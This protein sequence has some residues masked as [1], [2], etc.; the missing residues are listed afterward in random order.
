MALEQV[1]YKDGM[2]ELLFSPEG[3]L[4]PKVAAVI[5][6]AFTQWAKKYL[7]DWR[8]TQLLVLGCTVVVELAVTFG[9][10]SGDLPRALWAAFWG[11]SIAT[12]GY[13]AVSN[14]LG[15]AGIGSRAQAK[16]GHG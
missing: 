15:L 8:Y 10:G 1:F 3:I 13:E 16:E 5:A 12:F 9:L 14:W 6:I 7:G 2:M 4:D 11:A